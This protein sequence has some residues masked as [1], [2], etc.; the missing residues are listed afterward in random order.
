MRPAVF[1]L[2][3]VERQDAAVG[4]HGRAK[5]GGPVGGGNRRGQMLEPVLDPFDRSPGGARRRGDQNDVGENALL[6]PEAAAGVRRRAQ[7]QTVARDPQGPRQDGVDAEG[8]LEIRQHV[9]GILAGVIFGDHAIGLDRRAGVTGIADVDTDPVC[10]RGKRLFRIA[11]AKAPVAGD[12]AGKA[13][14]QNG[15]VRRARRQ[16][17]DHGW[18]GSVL[19]LDQV[20]GVFGEIAIGRDEDGNGLADIPHPPHRDRPAFDRG[21]DADHQARGQ[22]LDVVAGENRHHTGRAFRRRRFDRDDV[23]M[24]MRRAQD[25]GMQRPGSN[26]EI[27]D[28]AAASGQQR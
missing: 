17:I 24:G 20:C 26:P 23:G 8:T 2:V 27:V 9:V 25:R 1:D 19:D 18:P 12:I 3:P 15:S 11:V 4:G 16:R 28:E 22:R 21:L 5:G 6:D 13:V 10:R 14:M 7:P